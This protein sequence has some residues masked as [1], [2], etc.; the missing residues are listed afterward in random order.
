LN[1]TCAPYGSLPWTVQIQILDDG[2]SYSHHCGGTI[3]TEDFILTAAHCFP[4]G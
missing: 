4:D 1:G 3:I 2:S